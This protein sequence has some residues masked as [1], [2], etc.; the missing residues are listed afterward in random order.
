MQIRQTHCHLFFVL[1]FVTLNPNLVVADTAEDKGLKIA[2]DVES[3]NSGFKGEEST[4]VMT[5]INAQGD[6]TERK[7]SNRIFERQAEGDLSRIEFQYPPDVRG[8]RM[9][10]WS[11]KRDDDDQWLFLPAIKR[12]KRISS[13]NK[14]GSFMGSEFSYEDLGSQ[15]PEKFKHKWLN[16]EKYES[17]DCWKI[18]RIP[19]TKRSGYS[20]QVLWID[21]EYM[22]AVKIDYFDRKGDLLKTGT[23]KEWKKMGRFWKVQKIEMINHQTRKR[24]LLVWESMKIGVELDEDDFDS[25]ELGD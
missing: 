12:V 24:S 11:H 21:K 2:R 13:R 14:S 20:R 25:D 9:L 1:V 5:L 3:K 19:Q 17:R 22:N 8:T 18:E 10:T 7:M 4:I 23:F 16:D 15:E 6:Q